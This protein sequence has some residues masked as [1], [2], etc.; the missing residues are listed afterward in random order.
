MAVAPWVRPSLTPYT[1]Q[2]AVKR[3]K[4]YR[5]AVTFLEWAFAE[6]A[7]DLGPLQGHFLHFVERETLLTPAAFIQ[8]GFR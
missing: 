7:L 6:R 8:L 1:V 3:M 4:R 5:A 2:Q